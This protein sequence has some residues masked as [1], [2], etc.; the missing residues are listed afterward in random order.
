[1]NGEQLRSELIR[2]FR[3]GSVSSIQLTEGQFQQCFPDWDTLSAFLKANRLHL[4]MNP[5]EWGN[6]CTLSLD[7]EKPWG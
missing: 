4:H 3:S 2:E 1:M 7:E 5:A 6:T